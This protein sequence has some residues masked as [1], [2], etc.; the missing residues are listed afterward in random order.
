MNNLQKHVQV[1]LKT[2]TNNKL[3]FLGLTVMKTEDGFKYQI[4]RKNLLMD[5]IHN[6]NG[7]YYTC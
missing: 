5:I 1:T 2:E 3:N 7:Y 4:Y 6:S